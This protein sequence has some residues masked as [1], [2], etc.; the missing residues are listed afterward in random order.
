ME[1][2]SEQLGPQLLCKSEWLRTPHVLFVSQSE[3]SVDQRGYTWGSILLSVSDSS[4][5]YYPTLISHACACRSL[6][7][8]RSWGVERLKRKQSGRCKL[9]IL[10]ALWWISK[11]GGVPLLFCHCVGP[12]Y[13]LNMVRRNLSY[14]LCAFISRKITIEAASVA[15][16]CTSIKGRFRGFCLICRPD[17]SSCV[18][19]HQWTPPSEAIR[20]NEDTVVSKFSLR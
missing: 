15:A 17:S 11:L 13:Q 3:F 10:S 1:R 12:F 16:T 6:H 7:Q 20:S 9:L 5:V 19:I 14:I 2:Q 4:G 8:K 18:D